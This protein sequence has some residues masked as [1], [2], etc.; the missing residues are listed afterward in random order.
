MAF[1]Q[2]LQAFSH[3]KLAK[4]VAAVALALTLA[5]AGCASSM[6]AAAMA[7]ATAANAPAA[8]LTASAGTDTPA[9]QT[10][11]QTSISS[12]FLF[13]VCGT[14]SG[15][16]ATEKGG[17]QNGKTPPNAPIK[18]G[19]PICTLFGQAVGAL[20]YL[21]VLFLCIGYFVRRKAPLGDHKIVQTVS[22]NGF[23][24]RAPPLPA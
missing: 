18:D 15:L 21:S 14:L 5:W 11:N 24:S 20:V 19:C 16:N 13:S 6:H 7:F 22:R 3:V 4:L 23:S 9:N 1:A 8:S 10:V 12:P 17:T 2:S